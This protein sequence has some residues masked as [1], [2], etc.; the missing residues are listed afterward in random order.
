MDHLRTMLLLMGRG[1]T[2]ADKVLGYDPIAYWPLWETS[3]IT[4]QCLVNPA[5]NG[6]ATGVTWGQTGIGDGRTAALFDGINDYVNIYTATLAAA[7]NGTTGGIHLWAKVSGAGVWTDSAF[8]YM[9][10][11]QDDGDNYIRLFKSSTNNTVSFQYKAGGTAESENDNSFAG[12]A[13]WIPFGMS[14]DKSAGVDG[15]VKYFADGVQTGATDTGLG[16]W[17][18][19]IINTTTN[20]GCYASTPD[21]LW[22][23]Y[24]AHVAV[25]DYAPAPGEFAALAVV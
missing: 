13:G 25:F 18:G 9:L 5:Q 3:G 24:I 20:I 6:T 1:K 2:Y 22:D 10:T 21:N 12:R 15:E 19:P 7:F 4:A 8:R 17:V 23:G 11:L 14:W 16:N